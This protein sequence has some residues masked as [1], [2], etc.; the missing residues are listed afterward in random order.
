M[1]QSL[2]S[3]LDSDHSCPALQ[4]LVFALSPGWQVAGMKREGK[5]RHCMAKV[6]IFLPDYLESAEHFLHAPGSKLQGW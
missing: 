1:S 5:P 6:G 2:D 4:H 3:Y